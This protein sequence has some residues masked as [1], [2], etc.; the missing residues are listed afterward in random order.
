LGW[1]KEVTLTQHQ[2][3]LSLN[4]CVKQ[5]KLLYLS[6]K[7]GYVDLYLRDLQDN[8]YRRANNTE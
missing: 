5:N 6:D 7:A 1:G 3:N 2:L 8:T 4:N